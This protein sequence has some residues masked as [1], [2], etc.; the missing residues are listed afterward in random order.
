MN[1]LFV[2]GSLQPG[3]PNEHVLSAIG[4]EWVPGTVKG[5]LVHAGWGAEIGYPGLRLDDDGSDVPGHVF[6]SQNLG[7]A[8]SDLD[9]F[10][11]EGY[12]R[13]IAPVALRGGLIMHAFVYVLREK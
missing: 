7:S 2:Y 10:E 8:W 1:S 11:G 4:G 5:V 13:V 6:T 3:G 9:R 12:D